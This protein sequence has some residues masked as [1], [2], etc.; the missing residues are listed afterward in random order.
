[1][2]AQEARHRYLF[3]FAIAAGAYVVIV[4]GSVTVLKHGTFPPIARDLIAVTPMIA[5]LAVFATLIR[6]LQRIDEL[7]RQIHIEAFAIAAGITAGLGL[8]YGLLEGVGFPKISAWWAFM[9]IDIFWAASIP[10]I[11]RRYNASCS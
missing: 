10:F 5:I 2:T 1:M 7:Q 4:A 8:T 11:A 9:S 3:N 6:Y